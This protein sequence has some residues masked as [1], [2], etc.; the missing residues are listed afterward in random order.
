MYDEIILYF[1]FL[2]VK[3][4][5]TLNRGEKLETLVP[6]LDDLAHTTGRYKKTA[7]TVKQKLWW[8]NVK[9]WVIMFAVFGVS[10]FSKEIW[11]ATYFNIFSSD[12]C[13]YCYY[14]FSYII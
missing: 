11:I 3:L 1:I 13:C 2:I 14:C 5:E 6:K 8:K 7:G 12:L 4:D 10:S 9:V